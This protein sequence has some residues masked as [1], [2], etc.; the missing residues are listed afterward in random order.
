MKKV[1]SVLVLL[2][3]A[4]LLVACGEEVY[5]I[6]MILMINP[7]TKVHGKV[8]KNGQLKTVNPINTTNLQLVL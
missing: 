5:E 7:S 4:V 8:L 1:L 2:L 6:A 3:V